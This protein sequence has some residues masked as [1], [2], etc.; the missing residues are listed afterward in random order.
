MALSSWLYEK[1]NFTEAT[2]G[3]HLRPEALM[4]IYIN[5]V[6]RIVFG[7]NRLLG[8]LSVG[9]RRPWGKTPMRRNAHGA[10]RLW[11]ELSFHGAKCPWGEKSINPLYQAR[12]SAPSIRIHDSVES[13][14]PQLH[15]SIPSTDSQPR[16][17]RASGTISGVNNL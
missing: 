17:A 3:R 8:K 7:A 9:A 11:G 15:S 13:A 14:S 5:I 1:V 4:I 6:G 10:K 2:T 12:G 16:I